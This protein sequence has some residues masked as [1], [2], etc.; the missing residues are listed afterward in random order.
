L[1]IDIAISKIPGDVSG[2]G[3]KGALI[4]GSIAAAKSYGISVAV[5]YVGTINFEKLGTG[6]WIDEDRLEAAN[7]SWYSVGTIAGAISAGVTAGVGTALGSM[8]AS[9]SKFLSGA[10]KLGTSA[11][12]KAAE[13]ATYAA[14]SLAEGGTLLD[15]YDN[16]GGLTI[17]VAN[18]GAILDMAGS[19]IARGNKD[20]QSIFG[21]GSILQ[22]LSGIGLLE[23]NFGS[24]G[25]STSIGMGGIDVGGAL[26]EQV[27]RGIDYAGLKRDMGTAEGRIAYGLYVNGDWT[28]ENTAMRIV[29]G[30][31]DLKLVG[32]GGLG[33]ESRYGHTVQ[34]DGGRTITIADMGYADNV[35]ALGH[36]AYRD[37]L[38]PDENYLE[39]RESVMAHTKLAARMREAGYSFNS[40]GVIGLDLAMYD[41]ARSVG[42]M[43]IMDAYADMVYRSDG[44]YLEIIPLPYNPTARAQPMIIMPLGGELSDI[45]KRSLRLNDFGNSLMGLASGGISAYQG[46][47]SFITNDRVDTGAGINIAGGLTDVASELPK[48]NIMKTIFKGLGAAFGIIGGFKAIVDTHEIYPTNYI[49]NDNARYKEMVRTENDFLNDLVSALRANNITVHEEQRDGLYSNS[50]R[51][52]LQVYEYVPGSVIK[53]LEE[54]KKSKEIYNGIGIFNW[55]R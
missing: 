49:G 54:L 2:A 44:D 12:G 17:N 13:Y 41:Y 55:G 14:Y 48:L 31:D 25:I 28:M 52:N 8:D 33:S 45:Q 50:P 43:S 35:A 19:V 11:A 46:L 47:S 36:E 39:T 6:E 26:Y 37:G 10:I 24:D 42:D 32:K 3:L 51:V 34:N 7:E 40:E 4:N 15:A 53:V 16:M 23:V 21:D 18:L 29:N 22:K 38:T 9:D 5:S 30:K 1:V 20:N 27:K